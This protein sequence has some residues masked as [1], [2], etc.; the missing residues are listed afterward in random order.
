M[1]SA[2]NTPNATVIGRTTPKSR[3]ALVDEMVIKMMDI[4]N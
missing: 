4:G 1:A 3:T 2:L